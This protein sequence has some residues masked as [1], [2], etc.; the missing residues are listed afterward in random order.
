MFFVTYLRRELRRR[1]RQAIFIAL[2]LALGIGLVVTVTA[3]SAGVKKA[4]SDVLKRLYG[5]GTDVTV[6]G[7]APSPLK[8]GSAPP[9]GATTFQIGPGGAQYCHNGKCENA[10][11]KTIDHLGPQNYRPISQSKVA[12]VA[13]LKDVKAAIG[14]LVLTDNGIKIP[15]NFGGQGGSA[16][17]A[18]TSF[19]VDGVDTGNL[20]LGPLSAG[21]ITSGRSLTSA[22][23][24]SNVAVVDSGYAKTHKLK[25]G[26]KVSIAGHSFTVIGIVSQPQGGAPPDVY[27][28]LARAQALGSNPV[29]GKSL[30]SYVNAI[31]VTAA[32]SADIATVQAEIKKLLPGDTVTTASSLANEVTGSVTNAAKLANDL[33][34]WLSVLVLIAAF[35]I[36][37]LL[38]IAAVARRVREFGTLKALGWRSTRIIA[39]VL[40]ESLAIGIVG[41]AAGVGLGFA[42]AAIITS[43][44]PNLTAGLST[45][46]GQHIQEANGAGGPVSLNPTV[47]HSV[48]VPWSASVTV[49]AIVVAVLLAVVGGLLAGSFGGWR[50]ARLRPADALSRVA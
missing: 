17:P 26:K 20:S 46:T 39:Q 24:T 5:V 40:G 3:A 22:D 14:G 21:K 27:I 12:A 31:Y 8:P 32:S 13:A 49:N 37:S 10:A 4:Q 2:G 41:G 9:K 16:P 47:T 44:A 33:G 1:M 36:A 7:K 19:N 25:A 6:T 23:A 45:P 11:G 28:P 50:I 42:G 15:K 30:K 29:T 18:P 35:A 48:T 34:K 43:V 38:T